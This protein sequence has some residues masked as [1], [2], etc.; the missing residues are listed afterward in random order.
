MPF[1]LKN[2]PHTFSKVTYRTYSHL[3]R[4]TVKVYIDDTVT[5]SDTF[6]HHLINLWKTF[7][8]THA[9]GLKLKA[10]KCFFFYPEVEFIG[11]LIGKFGIKTMP[12][13]IDRIK[14]WPIPKDRTKLKS[15]L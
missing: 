8:V 15:F 12:S 13:K 11:H 3:I 14:N 2:A 7:K 6:K 9:S 10:K 4:K 1:S 5:Y